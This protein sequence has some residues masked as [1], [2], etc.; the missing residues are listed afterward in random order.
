MSGKFNS[1]VR[2]NTLLFFALEDNLDR[3]RGWL[4]QHATGATVEEFKYIH[5]CDRE[6]LPPFVGSLV[7]SAE[8]TSLLD[9]SLR[10]RTCTSA[11][12]LRLQVRTNV[13]SRN[14][15]PTNNQNIR[16]ELGIL[17]KVVINHRVYFITLTRKLCNSRPFLLTRIRLGHHTM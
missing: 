17:K 13:Q 10:Y 16:F 3:N 11:R 6:K 15:S 12:N 7:D 8:T 5:K 4:F 2:A 1:L 9:I 14:P